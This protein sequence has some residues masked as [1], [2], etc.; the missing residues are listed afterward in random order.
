MSDTIVIAIISSIVGPILVLL[1]GAVIKRRLEQ[2]RESNTE[3]LW[4]PKISDPVIRADVLK[5]IDEAKGNPDNEQPCNRLGEIYRDNLGN[6]D[7]AVRWFLEAVKR[8]P[9]SWSYDRIAE[10]Y[11]DKRREYRMA[12]D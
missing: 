11:R 8:K 2:S 12:L 1:V 3:S 5:L 6:Y 9:T 4:N 7:I 10:I